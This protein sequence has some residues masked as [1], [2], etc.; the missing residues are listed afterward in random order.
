VDER[1]H[2]P[3]FEKMLYD[4]AQLACVYLAA[5]QITREDLHAETAQA[6]LNYVLREMTGPEGAFFSAEDADSPRPERP[7]ESGEGVFY[8]WPLAEVHEVLGPDLAD[9]F[10]FYY[11]IEADGNV[12]DDP[13]GE[14]HGKN[15]L[16]VAHALAETA[17]RFG[18]SE[19]DIRTR[20]AEGRARLMAR[21]CR[22]PRPLRDDKVLTAWNG[23]MISAF[24]RAFQAWETPPYLEAAQHAADFIQAHLYDAHSATLYRR[25]REGQAAVEGLA[26]DYAFLIQGLLDLYE[27]SFNPAWLNWAVALQERQNTLFW[28][29]LNGGFFQTPA[30]AP[31]PLGRV[32][33]T[34]DGAEPSASSVSVLN[35]LRLALLADRPEYREKAERT[36]A[37]F[38][39]PLAQAPHALPAMLAGLDFLTGNPM[40]IIVA[41]PLSAA[42][43]RTLL[44]DLRQ[45]YL[46]AKILQRSDGGSRPVF[47]APSNPI[48]DQAIVYL[49]EHGVCRPPI[50]NPEQWRAVLRTLFPHRPDLA[51]PDEPTTPIAGVVPM[52]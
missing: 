30:H 4:Q 44:R 48:E 46:P 36:L 21:R 18:R 42:G 33:D 24:A 16:F 14:F 25:Y 41:G 15:I 6:I 2:V 22:R 31:A 51:R 3:H 8:V 35:L 37:A 39:E 10:C 12:R 32:K 47:S 45:P 13:H 26:E 11:G 50:T 23:L 20:L 40:Q 9:L 49:C 34:D 27:A 5:W 28:D 7:E 17:V 19:T 29:D 43:T 38:S 52:D 1:W